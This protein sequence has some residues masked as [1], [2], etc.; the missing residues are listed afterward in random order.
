[1]A[2]KKKATNGDEPKPTVKLAKDASPPTVDGVVNVGM[3]YT[4][5]LPALEEQQAGFA[6]YLTRPG[7]TKHEDAT[8]ELLTQ[9]P[10]IYKPIVE[11][12]E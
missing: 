6:P 9:F 2:T 5:H 7:H 10:G 11:K 3:E 8:R 12:G 4:I 1:M